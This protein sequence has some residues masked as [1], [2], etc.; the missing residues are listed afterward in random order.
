MTQIFLNY[1]TDDEPFGVQ[2]LD[3]ELSAQFGDDVVFLASKSIELG[4]DWERRMLAAVGESDAVLVIM[5]RNWLDA[6]DDH[7]RRRLDDPADVVRRE[8]L[9]GLDQGK[10]VIPVRLAV[11]RLDADSL[12]EALRALAARQDIEIRFRS[13]YPDIGLLAAKLRQQIPALRRSVQQIAETTRNL[14]TA[15]EIGAVVTADTITTDSFQMR[16]NLN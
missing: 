13:A 9:A 5:G 4:D 3:R 1:R 6:R 16:P 7:N 14:I 15:R 8:I 2:L 12:P 11:P 10:R